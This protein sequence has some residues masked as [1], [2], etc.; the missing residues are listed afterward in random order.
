MANTNSSL[1]NFD[2]LQLLHML[3]QGGKTGV[4]VVYRD[5]HHF[6]CW[7]D[8]GKVKHIEMGSQ[9][10]SDALVCLME[11]PQGRFQFE[12][13]TQH[14]RPTMNMGM[15]TLA[16]EALQKLPDLPLPFEGPARITSSERVDAMEWSLDEF[17]VIR[18]IEAQKPLK[19]LAQEPQ[20]HQL[21]SRLYRLGLLKA[22]KSRAARLL[23]A[24]T[25]EVR[26]V[27]LVDQHIFQRWK[28]DFARPP[29]KLAVRDD[30]GRT[31]SFPLRSGPNVG[32]ELHIPQELMMQSGLRVGMSV[33]VK[34]V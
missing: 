28:D 11:D 7:L 8:A 1:E 23:I 21:I 3:A 18:Q 12:E 15:D 6:R 30:R 32:T 9:Q 27:V 19:E 10:G 17:K 14:A 5:D 4:L 33:L 29:Q 16:L 34:P 26:G 22:R 2:F 31:Y 20:A 24:L 13:G 25:R